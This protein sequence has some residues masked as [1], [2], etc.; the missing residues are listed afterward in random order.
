MRT[1]SW[2]RRADARARGAHRARRIRRAAAVAAARPYRDGLTGARRARSSLD[3]RAGRFGDEAAQPAHFVGIVAAFVPQL[4]VLHRREVER[5]RHDRQRQELRVMIGEQARR[6][7]D[8]VGLHQHV[9]C[10]VEVRQRDDH[11]ALEPLAREVHVDRA[12]LADRVRR[13]REMRRVQV[14]VER[15]PAALRE[16]MRV[17]HQADDFVDEQVRQ[18]QLLGRLGPVADDDVELAVFQREL[19]VERGAERVE[20]ERRIRRGLAEALDDGR[21]EQHVQVVGAAD[22]VAAD[23]RGRVEIVLLELDALDFTQCVLHRFEQAQPVFGRDHAGLPAH[24]ERIAGDVAQAPQRGADR[25]LR[26]VQ[27]DGRAR[28]AALHQQG[29]QDAQEVRVDRLA[30]L[31]HDISVYMYGL[32]EGVWGYM[33]F[34]M[35]ENQRQEMDTRRRPPAGPRHGA[36]TGRHAGGRGAARMRIARIRRSGHRARCVS[37]RCACRLSA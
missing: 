2:R 25:R 28:D 11:V 33:V 12:A 20:L 16:R 21:H 3:Q 18:V 32:I 35:N 4:V 7:E 34:N 24:E 37:R 6:R 22:P 17:A 15:E 8:Q 31:T 14:L 36:R 10:E 19:V 23:R 9:R 29:V 1:P 5:R 26:L 13:R 30:L 27:F